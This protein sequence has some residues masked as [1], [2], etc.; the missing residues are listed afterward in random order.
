MGTPVNTPS[1]PLAHPF[2]LSR[3]FPELPDRAI[4]RDHILE[5]VAQVA[6]PDSPV[7][8]IEGAEGI[9][10]STFLAQFA[11]K[12]PDQTFCLFV[13]PASRF[14]Y[15]PD[16]L[17]LVLA[18]QYFWYVHGRRL[19]KEFV[20]ISEFTSL[21]LQV[22]KRNRSGTIYIVVDGLHQIPKEDVRA[23][24]LVF[25]EVLPV[26][27]DGFRF[28]VT[29]AQDASSKHLGSVRSKPYQLH[30]LSDTESESLL[31][32]LRIASEETSQLVKLCQGV[33]GRLSSVRRLIKSGVSA[34]SIL[35]SDPDKYLKFIGLEFSPI[36]TMSDPQRVLLALLAFS[37]H[38][39]NMDELV[40]IHPNA[41]LTD[42]SSV[43]TECVFLNADFKSRTIE[44]LSEA[45]RRYAEHALDLYKQRALTLQIEHLITDPTSAA[46]VRL[47]PTYYQSLN[48]QQAIVDLLSKEHYSQLLGVTQSISALRARASLGARSAMELKQ[49]K[50]ILQFALHKSIFSA[51]G[52]SEELQSEVG[53]LVA[54]GHPQRALDIASKTVAR[55][56][57]IFLLA[58]FARRTSEQ[59]STVDPQILS[60]IR[61]TAAEIDF[62]ELGES[63]V[64]LAEN[65]L[66]VDPD[67]ALKIVDIAIKAEAGP[68]AKDEAFA[69][70]SVAA[71]LSSNTDRDDLNAKSQS[72]ISS[73]SLQ[74]LLAS[75]SLIF[76]DFSFDEIVRTSNTMAIGR[77]IYFLRSLVAVSGKRENILDVIDH[78]LDQLIGDTSYTPKARDLA[79][80]AIPI[81]AP[82][83]D[84]QRIQNLVRRLE[85]QIGLIEK[86]APS[87]DLILLQMRLAH[88]EMSIDMAQAQSRIEETYYSVASMDNNEI[89]SLCFSTMSR[90]LT[91]IDVND[92]LESAAGFREIILGDLKA[93]VE[94]LL[95]QTGNHFQIARPALRALAASNPADAVAFVSKLNTED[96]RDR[97]YAEV[98][99]AIVKGR[100]SVAGASSMH[101]ALSMI[102][103][104]DTFNSAILRLVGALSLS[105]HASEWLSDVKRAVSRAKDPRVVCSSEIELVKL[106]GKL[107]LV[108][109][110]E[111]RVVIFESCIDQVDSAY[112]RVDMCFE[113]AAALAPAAIGRASDIYDRGLKLRHAT[114]VP[115]QSS[116]VVLRTCLALLSRVFRP[117]IKVDA[118]PQENLD[119]FFQIGDQI[120]CTVT[121]ASMYSDLACK[122]W[123]EGKGDLCQKIMNQRCL[124]LLQSSE[125]D[126][127]TLYADLSEAI[128]P[129]LYCAHRTT[130]FNLLDKMGRSSRDHAIRITALMVL[131]KS[132]PSE[133]RS[134]V[135]DDRVKITGQDL[136]DLS[137]LLGKVS[138]DAVFYN[139]LREV[140]TVTVHKINRT[141]IS[142]QQRADFTKKTEAMIAQKLPDSRNIRHSGYVIIC[143]AQ[144]LRLVDAKFEQWQA[145]IADAE[146]VTN[147]S[148]RCFVF[149]EIAGCLPPRLLAEQKKLLQRA[150]QDISTIPSA[151]DRY[152]C[153][154][155]YIRM[156]RKVAPA[157]AKSALKDAL[158]LT[159]D[160][161]RPEKAA[162]YRR[163]LVDIAEAMD[164][165]VL[166]ELAETIDDDPARAEAKA[167]LKRSVEVHKLKRKISSAGDK[168][169][170]S[171]LTNK[172]LP[173]AAWKNVGALVSDRLE[174]RS[175]DL[176]SVY[177]D[178]AGSFSMSD[179]YPVLCWYIEN[180]A[181]RY[182]SHHDVSTLILPLSEVLLLSTEIAAAVIAQ[183]PVLDFER[184]D[185]EPPSISSNPAL[186]IRPGE[187]DVAIEFI[188]RWLRHSASDPV[189]FC[190]PYFNQGDM[191]LVRLV[192][193]ECS[194]SSLRILTS[195]KAVSGGK[196]FS[197]E[198]FMSEWNE[199]IEQDPPQT[200]ILAITSFGGEE[201][202]VHDRWLL[203]SEC[204]LRIGTSF[205]SLGSK[206][207]EISHMP[208]DEAIRVRKEI[209]LYFCRQRVVNGVRVNYQSISL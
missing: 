4:D 2:T 43:C 191:E 166:D 26:G 70:L 134:T 113:L 171:Q 52:K 67:L 129:G 190:D 180:S 65:L 57:R 143:S 50:A 107:G 66:F 196:D 5:T 8:F 177:V 155:E 144:T 62:S 135:E 84:P 209:D 151:S 193:A 139:I 105:A 147:V 172:S 10:A 28:I 150:R 73:E 30:R 56:K 44:F 42:L 156:A 19:D 27:V 83:H 77:R 149:V 164:P 206:L 176:L 86:G 87:R 158:I 117:L 110:I 181:R 161:S 55:E 33:P 94:G 112:D 207:S 29:G 12:Y 17:R 148:D 37:R 173:S 174:P 7:V 202:I 162:R 74:K 153:L 199:I 122:A 98:A 100:H 203:G 116:A 76:A 63:A 185:D 92:E 169:D 82:T 205:N 192:L 128:F 49:A 61:E 79:D 106:L 99:K 157:E 119:R 197:A 138:T 45:H 95:S 145:I 188:R 32:D 25:K 195:R 136:V 182:T 34:A 159:F 21:Q 36:A 69:K 126:N 120:P 175:P 160:A 15:S 58:E 91:E 178:A 75:L 115:G 53:A 146:T 200:E 167:E 90:G 103:D 118:L 165:S 109:D 179:A 81:S 38:T 71:T 20:D 187:R 16:Y 137:E 46:A 85:G 132:A 140:V 189:V 54:L 186:V 51:V 204:G 131:R 124:P 152:D 168:V 80:L 89:R 48:Q 9:G 102:E 201:V 35:Q 184:T 101:T 11:M 142:G 24:D 64:D 72:K 22:R 198:A 31:D 127:P 97:A 41:T 39:M 1:P 93:T 6:T 111:D 59:G 141:R 23:V 68:K 163:N 125:Q 3:H 14:S 47:L 18:E 121:K 60:Y 130:A 208:K 133:P 114:S 194:D 154:E 170:P 78:T 13:R 183:A 123:C 40:Q 88:A 108:D 96:R 104:T